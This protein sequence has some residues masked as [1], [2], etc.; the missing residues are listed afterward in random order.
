M[1][2]E[3]R[4][5]VSKEDLARATLVTITNNIGSITRMCALNEVGSGGGEEAARTRGQGT[6]PPC[7]QPLYG[8]ALW[9]LD[10]AALYRAMTAWRARTASCAR[11]GGLLCPKPPVN[12]SL[13]F[14]ILS[15][16]R[17]SGVCGELPQSQH[18]LHEAAGLRH[19]LL[20][21]RTAQGPVP[22]PRGPFQSAVSDPR[23][24]AA[25]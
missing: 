13:P 12:C 7:S 1:S 17:K 16:H 8:A 24:V 21:Q 23:F 5:S 22:A 20:V 25:G 6:L 18:P 15:E 9:H 11:T 4:E 14:C 3:K 19:G 2:K 10:Q